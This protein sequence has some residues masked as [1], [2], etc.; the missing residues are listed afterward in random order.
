MAAAPSPTSSAHTKGRPSCPRPK[1][2]RYT[3]KATT[4]IV[5]TM[6]AVNRIARFVSELFFFMR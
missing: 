6:I 1:P 3:S 5:A 4:T 2:S